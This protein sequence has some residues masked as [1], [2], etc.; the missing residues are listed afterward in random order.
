MAFT[1]FFREDNEVFPAG[2]YIPAQPAAHRELL[3]AMADA[4]AADGYLEHPLATKTGNGDWWILLKDDNGDLYTYSIFISRFEQNETGTEQPSAKKELVIIDPGGPR[5]SAGGYHPGYWTVAQYASLMEES[6]RA[7]F[8]HA[9]QQ[10]THSIPSEAYNVNNDGSISIHIH[11]P[12][13]AY[14]VSIECRAEWK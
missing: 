7:V 13:K 3:Q 14:T 2:D 10:I 8:L 11:Q 12:E 6:Q 9:I 1:V 4:L 5:D